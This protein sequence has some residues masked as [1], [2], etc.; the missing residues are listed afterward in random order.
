VRIRAIFV[1]A[2]AAC[3]LAAPAFASG[4]TGSVAGART[5]CTITG[6]AADDTLAGTTRDDVICAKAGSDSVDALEGNDIVRGGQG[7]DGFRCPAGPIARQPACP[8]S[9]VR[10]G[11]ITDGLNG[12]DGSDVVK[13]QQDDDAVAGEDQN[14]KLYGGQGDDCLGANCTTSD[15][16]AGNDFL[17]SRDNV[18]GN[19]RVNGGS[20][21]D[22]CRIDAGDIVS[23]CEL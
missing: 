18:S 4:I 10:G 19:D 6:T 7:D 14:D 21:T 20:N 16:E 8:D 2:T 9:I 3:L 1:T 22:T 17:K 12:G 11:L 23:S 15:A 13:G 5:E